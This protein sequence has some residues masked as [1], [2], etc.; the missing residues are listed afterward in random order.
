MKNLAIYK[1][2]AASGLLSNDGIATTEKGTQVAKRI[3]EAAH[4]ASVWVTYYPGNKVRFEGWNNTLR[5]IPAKA[6]KSLEAFEAWNLER[7]AKA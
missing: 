6:L 5:T 2:S 7:I 1:D 3:N 4:A